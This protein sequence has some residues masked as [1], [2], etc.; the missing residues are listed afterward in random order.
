VIRCTPSSSAQTAQQ[1]GKY[2][3]EIPFSPIGL[4]FRFPILR[5]SLQQ[6]LDRGAGEGVGARLGELRSSHQLHR[7]AASSSPV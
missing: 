4:A 1:R 5:D 7:I 3:R 2:K 6:C